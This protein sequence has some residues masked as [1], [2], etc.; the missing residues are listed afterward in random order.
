MALLYVSSILPSF[1][2]ARL[3]RQIPRDDW[4]YTTNGGNSPGVNITKN[5]LLRS[6]RVAT[7]FCIAA[8]LLQSQRVPG[9]RENLQHLAFPQF[10][11]KR[12]GNQLPRSIFQLILFAS[13]C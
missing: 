10:H 7:G 3:V 12:I 8:R 4:F 13:L 9:R 11:G 6:R 2:K 5:N 1:R